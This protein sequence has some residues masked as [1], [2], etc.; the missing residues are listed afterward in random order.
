MGMHQHYAYGLMSN[1]GPQG[2]PYSWPIEAKPFTGPIP[3]LD[4]SVDNTSLGIFD[5]R[6]AR[7]LEVDASLYTVCDYRVLANVDKYHIKML[8]YEDLLA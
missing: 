6:Y 1:D 3:H 8:D 7:S 2:T 4:V 5:A